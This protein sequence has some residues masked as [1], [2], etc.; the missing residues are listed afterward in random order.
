M[1][2]KIADHFS[3]TRHTPWPR[4]ADFLKQQPGGSLLVDIGCGNGKYFGINKGL[5]E[6]RKKGIKKV[7]IL[8]L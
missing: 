2:E 7:M 6:V 3:G 1:Y 4:I 5:Y 8:E